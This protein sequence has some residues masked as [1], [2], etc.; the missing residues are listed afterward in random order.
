MSAYRV[1]LLVLA[2]CIG[3]VSLISYIFLYEMQPYSQS[4]TWHYEGFHIVGSLSQAW[5]LEAEGIPP[6]GII[7]EELTYKRVSPQ[8]HIV[9]T[10]RRVELSTIT[11]DSAIEHSSPEAF[12]RRDGEGIVAMLYH[13]RTGLVSEIA[14]HFGDQQFKSLD[15]HGQFRIHNTA[16]GKSFDFDAEWTEVERVFGKPKKKKKQ[17][18]YHNKW[19]IQSHTESARA[20]AIG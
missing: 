18:H 17:R 13:N 8:S 4:M 19:V 10:G 16:N 11:W 12:K 6:R 15:A 14:V 2:W 7:V 9:E 3:V 5:S 20:A 1:V